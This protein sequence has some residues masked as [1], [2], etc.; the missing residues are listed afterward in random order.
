[1]W[2]QRERFKQRRLSDER[3]ELLLLLRFDF[4][5]VNKLLTSTP[6]GRQPQESAAA[7]LDRLYREDVQEVHARYSKRKDAMDAGSDFVSG[8]RKLEMIGLDRLLENELQEVNKRHAH[9]KQFAY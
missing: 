5:A 1:M 9:R 2:G 3:V 6:F 7:K 8:D 4:A